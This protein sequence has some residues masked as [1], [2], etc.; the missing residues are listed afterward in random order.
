MVREILV[1]E[2]KKLFEKK[3]FEGFFLADTKDFFK[4]IMDNY[5]Y[6][7]RSN[8]LEH[9][10]KW[11]QVVS[12]VWIVNGKEK[13]VFAYKRAPDQK[14]QEARLR[15]KW[16]CGIGGHIDKEDGE[17]PIEDAMMR[18]LREEVSMKEYKMPRIVGFVTDDVHDVESVHLGVVGLLDTDQ[19][20]EKGNDEMTHG[21]FYYI[22]ELEKI[23]A[24]ENNEVELFTKYS[25]PFVKNY[26]LNLK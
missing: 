17:N 26:L 23:F 19:E 22:E 9:D 11:K 10:K 13:K 12:Y 18:E 2:R 24:D 4:I 7:G 1:V 8:E 16:S 5:E 3:S 14:Y 21:E 20:V 6:K 25:W 15:N